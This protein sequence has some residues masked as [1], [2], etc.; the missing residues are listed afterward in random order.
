M[1]SPAPDPTRD[2][3]VD[4]HPQAVA[5]TLSWADEAADRGDHRDALAWLAVIEQVDGAL[6]SMYE[7]KRAAWIDALSRKRPAG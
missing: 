1:N 2:R 4:R 3:S 6:P 5:R 7:T